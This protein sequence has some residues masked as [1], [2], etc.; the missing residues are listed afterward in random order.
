ML[1][2]SKAY[3]N[4]ALYHYSKD[5]KLVFQ[6]CFGDF[7]D[8]FTMM[9]DSEV[10]IPLVKENKICIIDLKNKKVNYLP[11]LFM[12]DVSVQVEIDAF[13]ETKLVC[14]R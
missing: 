4:D 14:I 13:I 6:H 5:N 10:I 11:H 3:T 2:A 8:A 1:I 9:T 7:V 12:I